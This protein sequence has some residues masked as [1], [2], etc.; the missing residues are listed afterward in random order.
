LARAGTPGDQE[1]NMDFDQAIAAHTKWR[2]KLRA[3]LAEPD[4]S[5]LAPEIALDN[6]CE[7]GIWISGKGA[8]Y[9]DLPEFHSLR[10]QHARFHKAVAEIVRKVDSGQRYTEEVALGAR[11]E[12][13]SASADVVSAIMSFKA[14]VAKQVLLSKQQRQQVAPD[15]VRGG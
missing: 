6:T 4:G 1:E 11:S 12:F 2:A 9:S 14:A 10:S 7:L 13:S 8:K 3:Y 15:S 5:L